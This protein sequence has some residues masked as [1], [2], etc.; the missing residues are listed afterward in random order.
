MDVTT[1][2]IAFDKNLLGHRSAQNPRRLWDIA[3]EFQL[4]S[5]A[6]AQRAPCRCQR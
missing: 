4:Q 2:Y 6:I 3:G 5:F 1:P